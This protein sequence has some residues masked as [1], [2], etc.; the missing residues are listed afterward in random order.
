MEGFYKPLTFGAA[1]GGVLIAVLVG[2]SGRSG[3]LREAG[4]D[5]G[6]DLD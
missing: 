1:T 2:N 3:G 6:V 5:F 4:S